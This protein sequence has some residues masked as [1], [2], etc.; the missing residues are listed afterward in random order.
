MI[1]PREA[2][3]EQS[4]SLSSRQNAS[5]GFVR[6]AC[7]PRDNGPP[8]RYEQAAVRE[9]PNE[10]AILRRHQAGEIRGAEERQPLRLPPLR[11]EEGRHGQDDGRLAASSR[12]LL[13]QFRL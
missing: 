3:R 12:L 2:A 8:G 1:L 9:E 7:A 6:S 13:A 5:R 11:P 10:Q 4:S